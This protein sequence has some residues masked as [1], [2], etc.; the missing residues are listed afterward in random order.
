MQNPIF[1]LYIYYLGP[2]SGVERPGNEGVVLGTICGLLVTGTVL[3]SSSS[4]ALLLHEEAMLRNNKQPKNLNAFFNI[5]FSQRNKLTLKVY[6]NL[7]K[8]H[9]KITYP[10]L[11]KK[12]CV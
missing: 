8:N 6:Q 10:L 9:D 1:Q 5:K 12:N 7:E 11:K 3:K 2:P 4:L